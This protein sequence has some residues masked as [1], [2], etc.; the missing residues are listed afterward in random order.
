VIDGVVT[1]ILAL[2][3]AAGVMRQ[4]GPPGLGLQ[5]F[6]RN[7]GGFNRFE[8]SQDAFKE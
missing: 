1:S 5:M 8:V 4:S 2:S 6:A 7:D 3:I